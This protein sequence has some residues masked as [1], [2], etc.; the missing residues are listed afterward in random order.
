MPHPI[1]DEKTARQAAMLANRI[2]KRF[3]HLH[4]RFQR[5]GLEIFRLYD[6]DIPE[7]RA[8]V[9]WY[10]GHL[11]IAEYVREQSMDHWL[12]SMAEAVATT[13]GIP[14]DRVHLK[15]RHAG[16]RDGRRYERIDRTGEKIRMKE[17]DL[18]FWINP[19]DFVDTGLFSDHR[20]TR[21]MVRNMAAGTRFLNLYC[22]TASFTCYAAAGGAAESLSIDRSRSNL[23]WAEENFILN[24][25]HREKHRLLQADAMD[26]LKILKQKGQTFSLAVVD[27]PSYSSAR[28][29]DRTFDIR[30]DHPELI[31]RVI[32]VM[33]K[34][35]TIFFSTNHQGFEPC[36]ERFRSETIEEI[37]QKTIPED[38]QNKQ[39][40]IHRCW[41][42]LV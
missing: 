25:T 4:K 3:K 39:K 34:G 27:P 19:S 10:A 14:M 37:T 5:E 21:A 1:H 7:I 24:G 9:D 2:Q 20:N 6:W 30:R 18:S 22:Y 42:I 8:V 28:E 31:T 11:V 16:I 17:R 40:R 13:L 32:Q 33:E 23:D 38:Y 41:R 36:M 35:S 12:P 15:K 26:Y 29:K